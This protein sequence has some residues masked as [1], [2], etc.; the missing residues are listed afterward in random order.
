MKKID[1]LAT[2]LLALAGATLVTPS[3]RADTSIITPAATCDLILGFQV[4]TLYGGD[5][6]A[7]GVQGIGSA[8]NL[9]IDLGSASQFY[10]ATPGSSFT[11]P[12]LALADIVATYGS[13]WSSRTDLYWGV[14]GT[15][16]RS[17]GS[18]VYVSGGLVADGHAAK[19]TIWATRAEE[20]AGVQSLPWSNSSK[21]NQ[22]LTISGI[23][24]LYDST[25]P[26]SGATSTTNSAVAAVIS[27]STVGSW[28]ATEGASQSFGNF[29]GL[30]DTTTNIPVGGYSVLDLYEITAVIGAATDS[31]LLGAFGLDSTG[32]LTF[33]TDPALFAVPE[34]SG[35]ALL[36]LAGAVLALRLRRQRRS[37]TA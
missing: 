16:G 22:M 11:L 7:L 15:T 12:A 18:G 10:N 28:T 37:I 24:P 30:I 34:P 6:K 17:T 35:Y 1:I 23:E 14:I 3:A 33:S 27:A 32:T 20:T 4:K 13:N 9:E 36:G 5:G 8:Y 21:S 2:A 19:N 29:A 25:S 26:L 31:T